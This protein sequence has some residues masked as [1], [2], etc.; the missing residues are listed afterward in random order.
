[1]NGLHKFS[2]A[3]RG[4]VA[5]ARISCIYKGFSGLRPLAFTPK[6]GKLVIPAR[7][8]LWG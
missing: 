3:S 6:L 2:G 1:M 5:M 8:V 7:V 4:L